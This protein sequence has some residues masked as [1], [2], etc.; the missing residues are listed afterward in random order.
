L[1]AEADDGKNNAADTFQSKKGSINTDKW[2]RRYEELVSV[3]M[4]CADLCLRGER[5]G[6]DPA[7]L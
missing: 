3:H 1:Q 2:M 4:M 6:C 7:R 5:E